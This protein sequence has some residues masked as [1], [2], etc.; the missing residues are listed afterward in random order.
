MGKLSIDNYNIKNHPALQSRT[1]YLV[2][3][4]D[5][6]SLQDVVGKINVNESN[7]R[8]I[9]NPKADSNALFYI[10][11]GNGTY[12]GADP[13]YFTPIYWSGKCYFMP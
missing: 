11:Y 8:G 12:I 9:T 3:S 1:I 6:T 2:V 7:Y 13:Y 4:S 5:E 10:K